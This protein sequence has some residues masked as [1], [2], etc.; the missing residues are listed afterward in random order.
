MTTTRLQR[1]PP[2]EPRALR[3]WRNFIVSGDFTSLVILLALLLV[4][5]L[6]LAAAEWPLA[7][8]VILPVTI[9]SVIFGYILSRSQFNEL[10]ALIISITYGFC[11]VLLITAINLGGGLGQGVYD[12]FVRSTVWVADAT[13]G[14][15]NQDDMVFTLLVATLFWFLAYNSAW[16]T[17]RIDRVWRVIMPPGLILV[18]NAIFYSGDSNLNQ[19]MVVFVFLSLLLVVRS[20]LDARE[21]N[22]YQSGIQAPARLR[23]QFLRVGAVLALV[24]LL[25]GWAIPSGDLQD[26]LD[27]F[28]QFLNSDPLTEISE[29]WN[30]LFSPIEATGPTTADYYGGE[31]L[32][33]GGAIRLGDQ[34]VFTVQAPTDRRY[35]WRSRAYDIYDAGS[36]NVAVDT[37]LNDLSPPLEVMVEP[38][39]ARVAVDQEYTIALNTRILH[40]APQ[41]W[42]VNLPTRSDLFYTAEEGDP[43]RAM[44]ISVIR[45][46][47]VLQRGETYQATSLMTNATATQLRATNT[48]YPTWVT[49]IYLY[50]PPSITPRTIDLAR[51]IVAEAGAVTPYDQ[52]KAIETWLRNNITYNES[53]P[54]PPR[55]REQIDW[56]LF[57]FREGYCTYY[58]TAMA[59]MLRG[60]GIP[61]RMVAGFAQGNYDATE[62]AYVVTE[63]DAHTWVEVY[64]PGYGWI[65][66][67]PTAAQAPLDREGDESFSEQPIAPSL[68]TVTPSFTPTP[69]PTA[70]PEATLT[71]PDPE[72]DDQDSAVDPPTPTPTI[73]PTFTPTPTA[74]PVIIPTQPAPI[75]P[76]PQN[77]LDLILPA[78]G[79]LL[80]GLLV[81]VLVALVVTFIWWWWEWRGMRGLSPV[82][83]AYARLER[84]IG[85]IGIKLGGDQTPEERR[86][87]IVRSVPQVERPVTA[88]TRLYTTERYGPGVRHPAEGQ[89]NT[90]IADR[91]W[92]E[93]RANILQRWLRRRLRFWKRD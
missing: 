52:A 92:S 77:P 12:I 22:W 43:A 70:T 63:R 80:L 68:P 47:R 28:Q 20:N 66:F 59:I 42:R 73:T 17:F 7:M 62:N 13:S 27:R 58:A 10:M 19:Y 83:R 35:Y 3:M 15:I 30:R 4:T 29:F 8:S 16:H 50:V 48:V 39:A 76:Q 2:A 45:P 61:A 49:N 5:P 31:T 79:L 88:I 11:L 93:T 32:Q 85:L 24:A 53:I 89:R 84:Y 91:A 87:N 46:T 90:D 44:N 57:D 72:D 41:P 75:E 86:K 51:D 1:T 37:R 26:R 82:T 54:R 40:I 65:E 56:L 14:G 71:P 67:E 64:F 78:L 74:T 33:L 36:W 55:D 9:I 23:G 25:A 60:L 6:S 34:T 38:D 21:W 81:L 69:P 18:T